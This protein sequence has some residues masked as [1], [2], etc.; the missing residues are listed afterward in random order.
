MPVQPGFVQRY[1]EAGK[2][3]LHKKGP[4]AFVKGIAAE[5]VKTYICYDLTCLG[6]MGNF[7]SW[8]KLLVINLR[9]LIQH[10]YLRTSIKLKIM[11][12][13]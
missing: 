4:T 7:H 3:S 5:P 8:L 11:K 13:P 12:W 9:N 1:N 2:L 6:G 10:P